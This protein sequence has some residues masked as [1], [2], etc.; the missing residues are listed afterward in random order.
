MGDYQVHHN[1]ELAADAEAQLYQIQI[2]ESTIRAPAD[3][4]VLTG[5]LEDQVNSFK[6]QGTSC[7]PSR[8]PTSCGRNCP[9]PR[10][11]FR[12]SSK[13]RLQRAAN[14]ATTSLPREN[15]RSRSSAS[16]RRA[17]EGREQRFQGLRV[18]A[19]IGGS[20]RMASGHGRRSRINI[21]PRRI[22]WIWTHKFVDWLRLKSWVDV[23]RG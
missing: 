19:G 9:W 1:Q 4:E 17:A 11:T 22:V 23:R 16:I 5:D 6:K 21:E 14:L 2:D 20:P 3:G 15:I 7:S 18:G 12:K 8:R 13:V 10:T